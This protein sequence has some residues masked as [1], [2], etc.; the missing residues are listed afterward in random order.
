MPRRQAATT[1]R[2]RQQR[3]NTLKQQAQKR[4]RAKKVKPHTS[5]TKNADSEDEDEDEEAGTGDVEKATTGRRRAEKFNL[6]SVLPAEFL[7]DSE[8]ESED[9]R[10]LRVAKKPKKIKF[11]DAIQTLS[12]EGRGPRD[13]IVGSTAYRVVADQGDEKLAPRANHNSKNVKE[14]LLHRRRVGVAPNKANG[15]FKRR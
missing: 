12:K 3:D 7:T 15:F 10:D 13:E 11:D 1:K 5:K 14:M 6:P 9:E 2:K 8:D 4:E